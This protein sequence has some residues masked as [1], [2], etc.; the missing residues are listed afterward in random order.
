MSFKVLDCIQRREVS[1]TGRPWHVAKV[2]N[3]YNIGEKSTFQCLKIHVYIYVFKFT[4]LPRL[5]QST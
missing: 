2:A 3:I 1:N 4:V 5:H